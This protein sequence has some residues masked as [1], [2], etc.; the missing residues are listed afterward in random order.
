MRI[1]DNDANF[2][3]VTFLFSA[4]LCFLVVIN[5]FPEGITMKRIL[6]FLLIW[7]GLEGY[8]FSFNPDGVWYGKLWIGDFELDV[9]DIFHLENDRLYIMGTLG[10]SNTDDGSTLLYQVGE[11][12]FR[13][14][15]MY[16]H[17]EDILG[18]CQE[19]FDWCQFDIFGYYQYFELTFHDNNR[20]F[21]DALF[22][23]EDNE[24]FEAQLEINKLPAT[25]LSSGNKIIISGLEESI[26]AFFI[27]VPDGT[28]QLKVKTWGGWGDPDLLVAHVHP[29]AL[30]ISDEDFTNEEIVIPHPV[31]GRWYFIIFGFEDYANVNL[32][33]SLTRRDNSLQP[34]QANVQINFSDRPQVLSYFQRLR[35]R[36]SFNPGSYMGYRAD[37]WL[38]LQGP[39]GFYYFDLNTWT[40][41]P[42]IHVTYQGELFSFPFLDFFNKALIDYPLGEYTIYFGVDLRPNGIIDLDQ[43]FY[44]AINFSL[45][46]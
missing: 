38:L 1:S 44:D 39:E 42:G 10:C 24:K 9:V 11:K 20:A 19:F 14:E 29:M 23:S 4:T 13:V 25:S 34:P 28:I 17:T 26:K 12:T 6:I 2:T 7:F 5:I 3:L 30:F 36:L 15:S 43:V 41:R 31:P 22:V 45:V 27:D 46:P 18:W 40:F 37:W 32:K 35:L 8:V 16:C 33:V 21:V